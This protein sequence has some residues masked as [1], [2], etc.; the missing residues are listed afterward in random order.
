MTTINDRRDLQ[1]EMFL[2]ESRE[3]VTFDEFDNATNLSD[4]FK[5]TLCNFKAGDAKDLFFDAVLFGLLFKSSDGKNV[6]RESADEI[7][8]KKFTAKLF[9]DNESVQL[10]DSFERFLTSVI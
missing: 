5:K 9:S 2:A 6:T 3:N 1:P 10:D 7:L 4:K 8:G